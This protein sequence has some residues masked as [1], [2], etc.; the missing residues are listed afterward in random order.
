M[1]VRFG[2]YQETLIHYEQVINI[3]ILLRNEAEISNLRF[4][5]EL[6]T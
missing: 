1:P 4:W 2:F 5:E 3:L 6:H